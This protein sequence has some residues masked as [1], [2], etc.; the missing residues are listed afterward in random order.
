MISL[1]RLNKLI[2]LIIIFTALNFNF[3][4]AEDKPEDIWEAKDEKQESNQNEIDEQQE[5]TIESPILSNDVNKITVKINEE[6]IDHSKQ[7]VIGIIDPQEND[8]T[9]NMWSNTNGADV[10][11]ILKRI[12][13]LKL[14]DFSENLLFKVLFTNAYPLQTNLTSKE[15]LKIKIDWLI[16]NRRIRDLETLL[17]KNPEVGQETQAIKFLVNEYLSSAEI[18]MACEKVNF[19]SQEVQNNYLDKFMIYCLINNDRKEEAQLIFDLLKE[20]GLKDN[21]FEN[22]INFLLGISEKTNQKILDNNL[23]NF[24]LSHITADNFNYVP[25]DKTDKYIWRYL[26]A[27]NLVKIE[28][29]DDE[30]TILTYEKAALDNSFKSEEIFNIYKQIVFNVSQ[31]IN[32]TEIYKNLPNY[33]ARALIYQSIL[34]SYDIER[35]LYLTFLLKDLFEKDQLLNVYSEELTNILESIDPTEIPE[36]YSELVERNLKSNLDKAKIEFNNDILHKSKILRHFIDENEKKARTEK[37]FKAVYKKIKRNKKYFISIKDIIVLESLALDGFKIPKELDYKSLAEQLT[38]P[39][40]LEEL[41]IQNQTGLVMLKIIEI[42]GEDKVRDLDP[43][44]IY[45]L[46]SILNKLN[47]KKIRNSIL[48]EVLPVRV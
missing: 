15:F 6:D 2:F 40:N 35:K 39:Q 1:S 36:S 17:K 26:S 28:A 30:D 18:K 37:D 13:K 48:S 33:K 9:L 21:F 38:V 29:I 22:K 8:F 27:A 47:L 5:I 23:L 7:T 34:L 12:D 43:E 31:L 42:I 16:K 45:F 32:A 11:K 44:T 46:N 3:S 25:N 19:I 20:R 10:K 41:A 14:S 24:Y 4:F